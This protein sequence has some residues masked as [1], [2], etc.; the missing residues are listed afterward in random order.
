V[1][2]IKSSFL[3]HFS[4]KVEPLG[5]PRPQSDSG[6]G[7]RWSDC[8]NM[9]ATRTYAGEFKVDTL[10]MLRVLCQSAKI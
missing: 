10:K 9:I 6:N 5:H 3:Q 2:D 7:N 4:K 8:C 1:L